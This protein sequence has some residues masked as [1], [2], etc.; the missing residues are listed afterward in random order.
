[1]TTLAPK[2]P[3]A[4]LLLTITDAS[5]VI[6]CSRDLL[7]RLLDDGELRFV[8]LGAVRRVPQVEIESWLE[9]ATVRTEQGAA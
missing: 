5:A 4:P 7:R 8:R 6:G 9:R 3:A 2:A 1:M